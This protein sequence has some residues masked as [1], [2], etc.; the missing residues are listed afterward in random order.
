M[1]EMSPV[2]LLPVPGRGQRQL[3][4]VPVEVEIGI[5]DPPGMRQVQRYLDDTAT[6]RWQQVQAPAELELRSA[7]T[8]RVSPTGGTTT[9]IFNVC[10]CC[11]GVSL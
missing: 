10:M 11:V 3:T 5:F 2:E 6:K 8:H 1:S 4:E 9:A 7:R